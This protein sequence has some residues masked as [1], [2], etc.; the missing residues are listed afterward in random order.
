MKIDHAQAEALAAFVG[1][2]RPDWDHPGIVAAIGK[3][4]DLGSAAA[5][6][7][8]LCKL[9]ENYD[10]RTPAMLADP[11]QHWAGTSVASRLPPSMCPE[12]PTEKAAACP[13]CLSQAV[14]RDRARELAAAARA[15][16][17]RRQ[18][19]HTHREP[20]PT[21]LNDVRRRADQQAAP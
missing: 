14:D 1:R 20:A 8:A 13:A 21:D 10:L 5:V 12:H 18:V 9:A 15:A 6:G 16:I 4:R 2:I 3:A 19:T 11:G 7:A 17:P